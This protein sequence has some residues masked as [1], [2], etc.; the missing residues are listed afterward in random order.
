MTLDLRTK[1]K[2][3][4]IKWLNWDSAL[5]IL[6]SIDLDIWSTDTDPLHFDIEYCA[7]IPCRNIPI[8]DKKYNTSLDVEIGKDRFLGF[9][10]GRLGISIRRPINCTI[11]LAD[12][13][14]IPMGLFPIC[15]RDTF[16]F[17]RRWE[18]F[19][20]VYDKVDQRF[21]PVIPEVNREIDK[22]IEYFANQPKESVGEYDA[23]KG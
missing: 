12:F 19:C 3:Q 20:R 16:P 6:E 1:M 18:R 10:A 4:K 11:F 15:T 23:T 7:K 9:P 2:E 17:G 22:S 13:S 5:D 8:L 14:I 21:P